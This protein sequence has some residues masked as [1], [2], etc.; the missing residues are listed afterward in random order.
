MDTPEAHSTGSLCCTERVI[1]QRHLLTYTILQ[2][3]IICSSS[4]PPEI[5]ING[6]QLPGYYQLPFQ[7]GLDIWLHCQ[8][9]DRNVSIQY[10][11]KEGNELTTALDINAA[12]VWNPKPHHSASHT[13][14]QPQVSSPTRQ[15]FSGFTASEN[16][17]RGKQNHLKICKSLA[18]QSNR[19]KLHY[20]T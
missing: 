8:L 12:I 20:L 14:L 4:Q 13:N 15:N 17:S 16:K 7:P 3:L 6:A 9:K 5:L 19:F 2:H 1:T 10:E 18:L 11:M